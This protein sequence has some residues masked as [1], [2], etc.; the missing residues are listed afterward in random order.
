[1]SHQPVNDLQ[2]TARAPFNI[3]YE[4]PANVVSAVNQ[5]GPFDILPGHADFF[6]IL[7]PCEVIVEPT[8]GEPIKFMASNGIVTVRGD[9]VMLFVNM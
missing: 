1:M 6:S 3:Y 9:E 5:V 2:V 8:E 7:S 4:G